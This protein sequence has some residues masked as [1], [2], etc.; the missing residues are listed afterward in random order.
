MTQVT[1]DVSHAMTGYFWY[2]SLGLGLII[3]AFRRWKRSEC[4][5]A[6]VGRASA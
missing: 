6:A 2:L 3:Y 4:G 5:P 1:V